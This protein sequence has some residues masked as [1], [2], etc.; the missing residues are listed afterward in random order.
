[1]NMAWY[2]HFMADY[3]SDTQHLSLMEHGAYRLL[4]DYY[5]KRKKP[6]PANA[7]LLHRVCRA[8]ADEEQA[9]VQ[10]V[11]D[12]FFV[13]KKD[14]WHQKRADAEISK[15]LEISAKRT[16]AANARHSK[17]K[18]S[19]HLRSGENRNG[20]SD[21]SA[22]QMHSK[23][24]AQ[25]RANALQVDTQLTTHNIKE[26]ITSASA[27]ENAKR[28]DELFESVASL[29]RIDW[30]LCTAEQR[31]ALNQTCGIL[32]KEGHTPEEVRQFGQWW[33]KSDWRG[34][35]GQAPTPSQIRE[36]WQQA[37]I[38]TQVI[39]EHPNSYRPGKMVY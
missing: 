25:K 27:E 26:R 1:M 2:P 34:R 28:K 30:K 36:M 9:A 13:Q 31:G 12:Q 11:L 8:F 22:L 16:A 24:T 38:P 6:L 4:L 29:C 5:Y 10:S 23:S 19:S 7:S 39:D 32:R 33:W 15:A 35:Q 3:E 17:Q 20:N 37:F 18:T 21:A 14:G